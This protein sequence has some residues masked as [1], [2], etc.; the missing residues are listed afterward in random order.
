MSE[1]A[2]AGDSNDDCG[3]PI[4]EFRG[5]DETHGSLANAA[6]SADRNGCPFPTFWGMPII[7]FDVMRQGFFRDA[8]RRKT[9]RATIDNRI[10]LEDFRLGTNQTQP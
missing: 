6:P 8:T 2:L 7:S 5:T 9:L 3:R 10:G 4:G 1:R